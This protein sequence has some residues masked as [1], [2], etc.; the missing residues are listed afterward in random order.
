MTQLF[1]GD[2]EGRVRDPQGNVWWIQSRVERV[3]PE[4]VEKCAGEKGYVDAMWYVQ[5]SLDRELG[6]RSRR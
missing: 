2:H 6:N 1:F 5:E 4:E 3:E